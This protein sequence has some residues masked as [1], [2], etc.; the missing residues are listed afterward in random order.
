MFRE[1]N[2]MKLPGGG[3]HDLLRWTIL[4]CIIGEDEGQTKVK[5]EIKILSLDQDSYTNYTMKC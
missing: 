2:W 3:T 4:V 5:V 1:T